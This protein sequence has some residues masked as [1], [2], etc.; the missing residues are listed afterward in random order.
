VFVDLTTIHAEG[1]GVEPLL[2]Y[3]HSKAGQKHDKP[4]LALQVTPDGYPPAPFGFEGNQAEKVAMLDLLH[5]LCHGY[6]FKPWVVVGPAPH[7]R[8]G[9]AGTE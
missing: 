7:L 1:D 2:Q 3:G 9:A 8:S 6:G 5:H 4:R